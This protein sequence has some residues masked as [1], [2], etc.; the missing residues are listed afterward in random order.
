[1]GQLDGKIALITG[2]ARGQG[3]EEA[4]LF[5]EEGAQVI[6]CDL[7]EEEGSALAA[8]LGTAARF[9]K[10]DVADRESWQRV[11]DRIAADYARLDILVNNAAICMPTPFTADAIAAFDAQYR[12]NQLGPYLGIRATLPLMSTAGGSIIN[13]ASASGVKAYNGHA[14]YSASKYALRGLTKVA[15]VDL[16]IYNIRVNA[17]LP[18]FIETPMIADLIDLPAVRD[19]IARLPARRSGVPRDI[20]N[21]ALFLASDNSS[22]C[23]GADFVCDGGLLTGQISA[24]DLA[25]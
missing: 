9:I 25:R 15:A 20:A 24:R 8:S 18:G 5:V 11:T 7:L 19:Q 13:I 3:A 6:L 17:I 12:V 10:L 22:Y 4:K 2:A 23:T 14:G 1:M 16:A 21:M